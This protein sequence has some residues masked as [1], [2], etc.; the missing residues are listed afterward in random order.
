MTPEEL[1]NL[2]H[3][4]MHAIYMSGDLDEIDRC[5]A[6][7]VDPNLCDMSAGEAMHIYTQGDLS[8][9]DLGI[10]FHIFEGGSLISLVE[11]ARHSRVVEVVESLLQ[12]GCDPNHSHNMKAVLCTPNPLP[13]VKLLVEHGA[14]V[15]SDTVLSTFYA[16]RRHKNAVEVLAYLYELGIRVSRQD[17]ERLMNIAEECTNNDCDDVCDAMWLWTERFTRRRPIVFTS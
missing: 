12:H 5:F 4:L 14:S 7:G 15:N 8:R 11:C 17:R 1:V 6:A 3:D 13:L 2:R 16:C 9:D 10:F